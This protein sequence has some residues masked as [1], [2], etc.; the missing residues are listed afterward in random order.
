MDGR[1]VSVK[2]TETRFFRPPRYLIRVAEG[3][4]AGPTSTIATTSTG[5]SEGAGTRGTRAS[6]TLSKGR[7]KSGALLSTVKSS[8]S[9]RPA[10]PPVV[11]HDEQ[12]PPLFQWCVNWYRTCSSGVERG[13]AVAPRRTLQKWKGRWAAW[14]DRL[15]N[16]ER[17]R[18]KRVRA[19]LLSCRAA[20]SAIEDGVALALAGEVVASG[21]RDRRRRRAELADRLL[22]LERGRRRAELPQKWRGRWAAWADRLLNLERDRRR[23][24]RAEL[25][26]RLRIRA[27]VLADSERRKA[28][29]EETDSSESSSSSSGLE[30]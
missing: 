5:S 30:D 2:M 26:W 1:V 10:V 23:R 3:A 7:A 15:L 21:A 9:S 12:P 19:E 22:N 6:R 29:G 28:L 17:D 18:R 27:M 8:S 4:A 16:V 25:K 11:E 14:T 24:A 20:L 13:G